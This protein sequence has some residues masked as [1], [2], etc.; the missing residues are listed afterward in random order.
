MPE[1]HASVTVCFDAMHVCYALSD[2][3]TKVCLHIVNKA[4][5]ANS[6]A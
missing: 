6:Y 5:R 3:L 4:F 2:F 1:V